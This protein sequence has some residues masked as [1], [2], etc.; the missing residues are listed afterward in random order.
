MRLQPDL[1]EV[2]LAYA[3][4][5]YL[6]YR[7][8]KRARV[9]LT[10]A[11]RDLAN[12]VEVFLLEARIDR[13][14]GMFDKAIREFNEAVVRDPRNSVSIG[15]LA[16]TL[17]ITRQFAAAENVY[18]RLIA[19]APEQPMLK[20]QKAFNLTFMQS[21]NRT[22]FQS[23]VTTLPASMAEDRALLSLRLNFALYDRDWLGA[24]EVIQEMNGG[25]DNGYFAYA[26]LPV[27]IGCYS[28]LLARLQGERPEVSAEF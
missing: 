25:E 5:L 23:A 17:I 15:D 26:A 18:D 16:T 13:R 24:K 10:I 12:S 11:E 8:Y 7:D 28:I 4:Q 20:V 19:L 1:P 3:V 6:S 21:G 27:P 14:E 9:Q 22:A 2:H